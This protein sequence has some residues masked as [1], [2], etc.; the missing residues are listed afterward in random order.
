[1]SYTPYRLPVVSRIKSESLISMLKRG[2]RSDQRDLVSPRNI[3]IEVGV[4]EKANGSALVKLG[5][6]QVLVGH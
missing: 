4:V 5:K 3:T 1:V 2:L 6:T